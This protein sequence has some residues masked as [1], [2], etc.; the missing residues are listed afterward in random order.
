MLV[1]VTSEAKL[2]ALRCRLP[3]WLLPLSAQ[4]GTG[5]SRAQLTTFF[6]PNLRELSVHNVNVLFRNA[7]YA[8]P[9]SEPEPAG[10]SR[11]HAAPVVSTAAQG[12]QSAF[13][14]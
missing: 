4:A 13:G 11:D 3:G 2:G 9:E 12:E 10:A 8:E 5:P 6:S 14:R 1:D 7:R